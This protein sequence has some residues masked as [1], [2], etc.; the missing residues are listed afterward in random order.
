MQWSCAS[1]DISASHNPPLGYYNFC[2]LDTNAYHIFGISMECSVVLQYISERN[3]P[4][5]LFQT[6]CDLS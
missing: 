1:K 6:H 4:E 2:Q 3:L 5:Q